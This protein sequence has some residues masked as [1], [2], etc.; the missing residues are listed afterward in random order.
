MNFDDMMATFTNFLNYQE[1][2]SLL[3]SCFLVAFIFLLP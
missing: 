2:I 1:Y 3:V